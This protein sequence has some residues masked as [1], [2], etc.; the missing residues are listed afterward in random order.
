MNIMKEIRRLIRSDPNGWR[1]DWN[2]HYDKQSYPNSPD[3][4]VYQDYLIIKFNIPYRV[5]GESKWDS[6]SLVVPS[7][8]VFGWWE[9]LQLRWA[10]RELAALKIAKM[11]EK[12]VKEELQ[13]IEDEL[14]AQFA[15]LIEADRRE[16]TKLL[17]APVATGFM[18]GLTKSAGRK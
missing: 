18:R 15:P 14:E 2:K 16:R 10:L 5:Y 9:R 7:P 3:L 13:E 11:N 8:H 12:K 6:A 1:Y 4:I 17:E